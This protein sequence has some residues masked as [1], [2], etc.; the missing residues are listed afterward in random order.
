MEVSR[1]D[2]LA[3][4]GSV[5]GVGALTS[6]SSQG[7]SQESTAS[8]ATETS[9][10][11]AGNGAQDDARLEQARHNVRYDSDQRDP[12]VLLHISDIHG[13]GDALAR[14]MA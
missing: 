12:L 13:N 8:S 1:R 11:D 7:S 9:S 3:L 6:C 10:T 4:F 2:A 14:A 5:I